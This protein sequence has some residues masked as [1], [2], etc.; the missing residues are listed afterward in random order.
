MTRG[1]RERATAGPRLFLLER[2]RLCAIL[3]AAWPMVATAAATA[4]DPPSVLTY[5]N[6]AD[7]SGNF[8]VPSLTAERARSLRPDPDFHA[9]FPGHV[10]AQPLYW[11]APGSTSAMLLVATEDDT[12][13][14]LDAKTGKQIWS[15]SLG[16]P[17]ALSS[18]PC[19]DIDPLGITGTPVIDERGG[20][21]YLDAVIADAAGAHHR[22]FAL[23][24]AD[25]SLLS[26]WPID[27]AQA[28]GTTGRRF[29]PRNHNQRGALAIV[30]RTL[31]V[32]FS[33]HF[34][35]CGEYHG[36]VV[37][38]PLDNPR[39]VMSWSTR[40]RGGG[41]WAPGGI[42]SDGRD[43]F[44][45]TGNTLDAA[46]WSDGEAVFRLPLDLRR[47]EQPQDF[48]ALK[49]WR[50]RDQRDD[51]LGGTNPLPLA[52]G[53][54]ALLLALGKDR[55]A[56]L[57]DRDNLGGIGGSLVAKTVARR[58]IRTAPAAY[59]AADG[60][61]VAFQ[62]EGAECPTRRATNELMVLRIRAGTPPNL[63]TA[64]C[65]SLSG[66]GAPI[67]TTT[68]GH[69]EPIVWIVGAEG[70]NRLHGFKGDTGESL[71][72]GGERGAAMPGLHRFQTLIATADRLYVAGDGHIYAFAF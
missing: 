66:A 34:G 6:S 27:V 60:V 33:G 59:P 21:I 49:D 10:Y 54:Q 16:K 56:Y 18:L 51:D 65:G 24:L 61:L 5:H 17:A 35:D 20:A 29:E 68:N 53:R 72:D 46:T 26:G 48:F 44:V 19:G 38:V 63:T 11:R 42:A 52:A 2:W 28:L 30:N 39:A 7:R 32:P 58:A 23:S 45:A 71:F 36:W 13:L 67:V 3:L 50:E 22:L 25:G 57:L 55:H 69:S 1:C 47:S 8:I 15:R 70:D 12:V 4:A 9:A 64:W 62:G 40:G 41:I 37:G 31:Y 43:L 14:A